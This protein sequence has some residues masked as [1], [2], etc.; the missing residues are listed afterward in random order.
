MELNEFKGEIEKK[1]KKSL[2]ADYQFNRSLKKKDNT[3]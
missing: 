1:F 3:K 2:L